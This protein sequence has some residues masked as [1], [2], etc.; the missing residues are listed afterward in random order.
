MDNTANQSTTQSNQNVQPQQPISNPARE[1][2]P[3]VGQNQES[4]KPTEHEPVLHP[5]VE[6]AGVEISTN[7]EVP[8]LT[9]ED[10]KA[11]LEL[12]KESTPVPPPSISNVMT[13][14]QAA[15]VIKKGKFSDSI[16]ALAILIL[17]QFKEMTMD[18][19]GGK[20]ES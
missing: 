2:A 18:K 12:A 17:K 15:S 10:K 1:Q 5:E 6:K 13:Q 9:L 3:L 16:T 20:H 19:K 8:S 4:Y 14:Q 7:K 11:G